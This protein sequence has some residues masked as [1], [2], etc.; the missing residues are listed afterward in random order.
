V[1]LDDGHPEGHEPECIDCEEQSPVELI[2]DGSPR[3]VGTITVARLLPSI[4]RRQLGPFVFLDHMG[5]TTL[6]PGQGFDVRPHP[7][8]GLSTVTYFLEGENLHRDS[9][10]SVQVNRPEDINLMTSGRGIVHSERATPELREHGGIMHGLQ[11]WLAL[12]EANELDEPSFE[13]HPKST[14]PEI[15]PAPG[16]KGRVL[17]GAAFGA[18]SPVRHPSEPL[19]VGLSLDE[20][21][22]VELPAEVA[23]RGVYVIDGE[24]QLGDERFGRNHLAV[25]RGGQVARVTALQAT[26]LVFLGGAAMTRRYLEWNFVASTQEA[27]VAARERWKAQEFPKI[28]GDDQE[29]IPYPDM[30]RGPR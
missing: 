21:A 19:L 25:L 1:S 10:G 28:P 6:Q 8:I 27:L 18:S 22:H 11:M 7:H 13:H 2:L 24:V 23:E 4:K 9:L 14:L 17:L 5:P 15:A 29:F 30:A 26:R 20:G 3:G 12:P 16:V